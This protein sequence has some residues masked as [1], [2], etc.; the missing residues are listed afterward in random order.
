MTQA[1]TH[2]A[3]EGELQQLRDHVTRMGEQVRSMLSQ[4]LSAL[5]GGDRRLAHATIALDHAV[6]RLEV[7]S[8][9]MCMKILARRQPVAS[10]L[11]F[12]AT[13][14]KLVTDLERIGDLCVN[15]CERAIELEDPAD[16]EIAVRLEEMG[17]RVS[18]MSDDAL[19]AFLGG[20]VAKAERVLEDDG[21]VDQAYVEIF[22]KLLERMRRSEADL[23]DATR[24]QSIA[25]HLE[26][27]GDHATNVA[28]MV[29]FMVDA[30]DVRHPGRLAS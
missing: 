8:D 20:D 6:N 21:P 2:A 26:R 24:L 14:H 16:A 25:K 4:S 27:I 9:D 1:H 17:T 19:A 3:Y 18:A 30:R 13:A 22:E 15:I 28:E 7:E 5:T 29:I 11:R 10:D 23:H 12:V